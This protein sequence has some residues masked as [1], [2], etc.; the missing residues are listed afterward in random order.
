MRSIA[1]AVITLAGFVPI[2]VNCA[3]AKQNTPSSGPCASP[4]YA[5]AIAQP[6]GKFLPMSIADDTENCDSLWFKIGEF[7]GGQDYQSVY[8]STK[9]FI[10]ICYNDYRAPSMFSQ[11]F[12]SSL[13]ILAGGDTSL[14]L[15]S[16]LWLES[17]LYLNTTN[18]EYFCACVEAIAGTFHSASDTSEALYWKEEN[19]GLAIGRW[20]I[21]NTTCDTPLIQNNFNATRSS[22]YESWLNDTTVPLDTTL[23]SLASLGL[24][25]LL[26]R[27]FLYGVSDNVQFNILTGAT[28]SPNPVSTGTVITF[29]ISQEAYV[30]IN[31]FNV[32]GEQ[33]TSPGYEGLFQPGNHAVPLSL[34]GL[35]SGTYY[36]RILTA[37]GSVET[38]KLVKE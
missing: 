1:I 13:Q 17:V 23:P 31:L 9:K 35:P 18:P 3:V 12:S 27:H 14:W 15:E 2:S 24:D 34:Q 37:F 5:G 10:E 8:D 25:T 16:R 6:K 4:S 22:Q 20:L 26:A 28:A 19:C 11:Y 21:Q 33:V 7:E 38:V 32:L 30:K 29:G 36:A